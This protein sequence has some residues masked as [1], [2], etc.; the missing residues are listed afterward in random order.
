[1]RR[2]FEAHA[3]GV[4]VAVAS[5]FAIVNGV[6]YWARAPERPSAELASFVATHSSPQDE[7]L[8]W[9]WRPHLLFDIDRRFATRFLSNEA[10]I[11]PLEPVGRA[12]ATG[13]RRGYDPRFWTV[14]VR[15]LMA[16]KPRLIL[17]DPPEESDAT[18]VRY[19]ALATLRRDYEP[20]R[21]IDDVCVYVR[22]SR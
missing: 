3:L 5:A 8:L 6:Y 9:T 2:W 21:M 1:A 22:K 15:D 7:V 18:L 4:M 17:D 12:G 14:F 19:P 11:G 20:C 10:L 16:N 13:R